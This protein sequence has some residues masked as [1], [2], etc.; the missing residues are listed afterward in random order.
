ME[1]NLLKKLRIVNGQTISLISAPI[2]YVNQLQSSAANVS[3]KEALKGKFDQIHMFVKSKGELEKKLLSCEKSLNDKGMLW[4]CYPKKSSKISTDLDRNSG[5][6]IL[7]KSKLRPVSFIAVDKTWTAFGLRNEPRPE[8]KI[9][10]P[11]QKSLED[12]YIDKEKRIV[13]APKDLEKLFSKNKKAKE[14]FESLSFSNKKEYVIW[15]IQAKREETRADRIEKTIKM[16]TSGKKNP[17][18]K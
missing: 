3:F 7:A 6:K 18:E 5:W 11:K 12:N 16:L 15:I 9:I 8:K 4:I 2:D 14:V 10:E 17:S 13:K 1:N